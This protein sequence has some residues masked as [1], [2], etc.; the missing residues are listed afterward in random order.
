MIPTIPG[1]VTRP[2]HSP[3]WVR[4]FSNFCYRRQIKARHCRVSTRCSQS[5]SHHRQ[6]LL[7]CNFPGIDR[8]REG[9]AAKRANAEHWPVLLLFSLN[10][11]GVPAVF[12]SAAKDLF[13]RLARPFAALG[14]TDLLSKCL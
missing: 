13:G 2:T 11:R 7:F 5:N 14:V 6:I 12:L 8:L 9:K 1:N 10:L 3:G 4:C